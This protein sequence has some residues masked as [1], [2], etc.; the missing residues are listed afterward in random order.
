MKKNGLSLK[1]DRRHP[2]K[3]TRT[4]CAA[5]VF[6]LPCT[7]GW[8]VPDAAASDDFS[9]I[10][11]HIEAE[12]HV[13]R[14][15]RFLMAFAGVAVRLTSFTGVKSFKAAI[16]ENQHLFAAEPDARLDEI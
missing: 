6:C 12:Y 13:H 4:Y 7:F 15:Y 16:F 8:L 14:N 10:V 1:I 3:R 11:H 5:L 2:M 9:A